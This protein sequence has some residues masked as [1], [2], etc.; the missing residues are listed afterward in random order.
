MQYDT[1]IGLIDMINQKY[2]EFSKLKNKLL[3]EQLNITL[4]KINK[5]GVHAVSYLQEFEAGLY[6]YGVKETYLLSQH[7]V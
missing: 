3:N 7:G 2:P 6:F 1:V 4:D 5:D